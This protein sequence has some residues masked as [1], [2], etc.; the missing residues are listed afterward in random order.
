M[1]A[2]FLS[3]VVVLTILFLNCNGIRDQSK[4]SGLVQWLGSLPSA[5]DV[6]CLQETHCVS[7]AEC[8]SW[9][10]SSGFLSCVSPGSNHSCGCIVL[11]RPALSLVDSWSDDDGRLLQCTFTFFGKSFRVCCIHAPNRNLDRDRFFEVVADLVDP[12]VPTLLVGDFNTV[13]DRTK[14]RRGSDP[15]DSGRALLV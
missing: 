12:S 14:D 5:V 11:H 4:R 3:F 2:T 10:A 15:L 8:T 9:F 13:F 7:P 6:V 1:T